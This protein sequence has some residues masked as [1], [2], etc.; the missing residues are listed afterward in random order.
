MW[1]QK[2][3]A[4]S[5]ISGVADAP[6]I[7]LASRSSEF[8][9]ALVAR[10]GAMMASEGMRVDIVG[11]EALEATESDRYDAVVVIST[12]LAWGF[13]DEV[14]AFIER[15]ATH[16][17]MIFVTTSASGDWMPERGE[18]AYDAIS[19]ASESADVDR[20]AQNIMSGIH[21]AVRRL[22]R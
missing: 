22:N 15:H 20:V 3:M 10:L 8:K 7:L 1:P 11:V 12:C 17:N 19:S 5:E 13:D 4:A 21:A 18:L 9:E 16:G 14:H 2:D 6:R